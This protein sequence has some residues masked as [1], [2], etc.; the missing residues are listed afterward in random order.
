ME[1]SV[2]TVKTVVQEH[3]AE[4]KHVTRTVECVRSVILERLV[5]IVHSNAVISVYLV[6]RV[7]VTEMEPVPVDAWTDGLVHNAI[8]N[9]QLKTAKNATPAIFLVKFVILVTI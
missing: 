4:V 7:F 8:H 2:Q 6:Y 9:V 1:G 3:A 5:Q